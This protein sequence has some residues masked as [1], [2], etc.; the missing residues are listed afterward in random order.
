M[1]VHF[2]MFIIGGIIAEDAK[3]ELVGGVCVIVA[4]YG[5]VA[6]VI[7]LLKWIF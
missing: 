2:L 4:I 1:L 7:D 6:F 5:F 3:K